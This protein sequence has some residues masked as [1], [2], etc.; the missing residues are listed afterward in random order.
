M[1]DFNQQFYANLRA[2]YKHYSTYVV[3]IFSGL[4]AYWLQMPL[5]EQARVVEWFPL[6]K[7]AVPFSGFLS[8]MIARGLPQG[9]KP[10]DDFQA[11]VPSKDA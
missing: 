5:E 7:F 3:F 6:L 10:S 1:S 4:G 8:F 2:L 9:P 11:T